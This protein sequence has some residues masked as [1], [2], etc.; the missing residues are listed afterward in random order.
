MV[1]FQTAALQVQPVLLPLPYG[2]PHLQYLCHLENKHHHPTIT[3][4]PLASCCNCEWLVSWL[5]EWSYGALRTDTDKIKLGVGV[6]CALH[7]H[8]PLFC[9]SFLV[10]C[11]VL[12]L[13]KI[14]T[15]A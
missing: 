14:Y 2:T 12:L 8:P 5:S 15:Q 10:D 4:D 3:R 6:A 13:C 1:R 11:C 9:V 7:P